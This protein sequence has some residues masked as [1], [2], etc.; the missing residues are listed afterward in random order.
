MRRYIR[1]LLL[2]TVFAVFSGLYVYNKLRYSDLH[3]IKSGFATPRS[4][5]DS[6]EIVDKTRP[7]TQHWYNRYGVFLN[8]I[9]CNR[10]LLL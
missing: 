5:R 10:V 8:F 7:G 4:P 3:R 1:A 6:R 2:C 9:R